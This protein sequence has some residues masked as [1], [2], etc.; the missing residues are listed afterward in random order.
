MPWVIRTKRPHVCQFPPV[1]PEQMGT[2]WK[3]SL[4]DCDECGRRYEITGWVTPGGWS[5]SH[6]TWKDVTHRG[7]D[8]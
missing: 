1:P 5:D 7:G 3:G 4:W 6:P 2:Y 8:L